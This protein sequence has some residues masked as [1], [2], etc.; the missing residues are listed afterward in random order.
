M[1]LSG[2]TLS[3]TQS[4]ASQNGYLSSTDWNLFNNKISSSS[5]SATS[6]LSYNSSTGV[7]SIQQANASQNGYLSSTDWSTFNGKLGSTS[8]SAGAG[9]SYN[10]STGVI[11][12]TI[13]YE[14]PN[15][16]TTTQIA[17]NGGLTAVGAT[18]TALAVTGSTTVSSVLNALGGVNVEIGRAHV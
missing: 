12:N 13:G 17:F 14:F 7:F 16:A 11:T 15:N 3:I 5:L 18:T 1:S 9:I 2:S 6:P 8:L 4:G 10:S